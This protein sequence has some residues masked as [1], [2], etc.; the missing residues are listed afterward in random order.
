MEA[1]RVT[2][3]GRALQTVAWAAARG[4]DYAESLATL[5]RLRTSDGQPLS[6]A[7]F[8]GVALSICETIE[9]T[10][11][12]LRA[13]KQEG[14]EVDPFTFYA[15]V[16][17]GW[18]AGASAAPAVAAASLLRGLADGALPPHS[19]LRA[20]N[21]LADSVVSDGSDE[22][23][24]VD[25]FFFTASSEA[26]ANDESMDGIGDEAIEDGA[27][28]DAA[29]DDEAIDDRA[30]DDQADDAID[31]EDQAVDEEDEAVVEEYEAIDE[32]DE[33]EMEQLLPPG[34]AEALLD[35]AYD[36]IVGAGHLNPWAAEGTLDLH[37]YSV[38]LAGA[39]VRHVLSKLAHEHAEREGLCELD[40]ARCADG[41]IFITGRGLGS[42]T[43]GPLLGPAVRAMLQDDF[44]PPIVARVADGNEGRLLVDGESLQGW[45]AA[46]AREGR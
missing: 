5:R 36:A 43:S 16:L 21:L 17:Q 41:L 31:E 29:I 32:E 26:S 14:L 40:G 39:A 22:E 18:A 12:L 38:A 30:I 23:Q 20:L 33:T 3:D 1:E 27:I 6:S 9:G 37:G 8:L 45:L 24:F 7:E 2:P 4:G 28:D 19:D 35:D 10:F 44:E 46:N 25:F 34:Y 42:G 11:E 13:A 15:A